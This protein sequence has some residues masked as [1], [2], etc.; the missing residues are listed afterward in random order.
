MSEPKIDRRSN[1]LYEMLSEQLN[2]TSLHWAEVDPQS[3]PVAPIPCTHRERARQPINGGNRSLELEAD[4]MHS[5]TDIRELYVFTIIEHDQKVL[6]VALS[7]KNSV[8]GVTVSTNIGKVPN[9]RIPGMPLYHAV[10]DYIQ[11]LSTQRNQKMT[12]R[13]QRSAGETKLGRQVLGKDDWNAKFQNTLQQRGY[14]EVKDCIWEKAYVPN[15][16]KD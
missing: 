11:L 6:Q 10:L 2:L 15:I 7:I 5:D 8:H 4:H 3:D 1:H 12:H 16:K 14:T 9:S 13:V